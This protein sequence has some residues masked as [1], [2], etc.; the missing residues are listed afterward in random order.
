MRRDTEGM[1]RDGRWGTGDGSAPLR[2]AE[3]LVRA[4]ERRAERTS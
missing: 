2:G 3:A 1:G 4:A